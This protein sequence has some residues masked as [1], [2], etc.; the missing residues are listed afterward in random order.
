M[1]TK[2]KKKNEEG[3]KAKEKPPINEEPAMPHGYPKSLDSSSHIQRVTLK[4]PHKSISATRKVHIG[5]QCVCVSRYAFLCAH[6]CVV[7]CA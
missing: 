2:V 4:Q 5:W 1:E 6:V 3:I 7:I